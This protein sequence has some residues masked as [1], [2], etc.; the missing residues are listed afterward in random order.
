MYYLV[1]TAVKL[2][3]KVTFLAVVTPAQSEQRLWPTGVFDDD[4]GGSLSLATTITSI[5]STT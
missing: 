2:E 3:F 4:L 1:Q 5:T